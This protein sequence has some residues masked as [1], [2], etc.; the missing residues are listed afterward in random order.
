M[1]SSQNKENEKVH[2]KCDFDEHATE[3]FDEKE[4][5]EAK[6]KMLNTVSY[7]RHVRNEEA[8]MNPVKVQNWTEE[9]LQNK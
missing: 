6:E 5:N 1:N 8:E 2:Q 3:T 7:L 4:K 9:G